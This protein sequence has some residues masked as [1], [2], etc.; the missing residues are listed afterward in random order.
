MKIGIY[1][2]GLGQSVASETVVKY[3]TRLKN[4]YS[5]HK[6]GTQYDLKVE[7]IKYTTERESNVVSIIEKQGADEKVMYRFYEFKYGDILTAVYNRKNILLKN[8]MLLSV[9]LQKTPVLFARL[10]NGRGYNRQGQTLYIFSLFFVIAAAIL[11]MVPATLT[12]ISGFFLEKPVVEFLAANQWIHKTAAFFHITHHGVKQFSQ[13]F[14]SLTAI[15]LL[16]VPKANVIITGLATEFVC[17]HFYLQYGQQKQD[18][19]GNIDQLVEYIV[20]HEDDP[21]IHFHTYSFGS[22][23]AM[24]Y[25]FAFGKTPSGNMVERTESLLTIGTPFDFINA[26]YP[27]YYDQRSNVLDAKITWLNVYS[28]TDALASNFRKDGNKGDAE[29][30]ISENAILKPD[31]LNYEVVNVSSNNFWGALFLNSVKAHGMYW[32][33]STDGSSCLSVVY[34]TFKAKGLI[35]V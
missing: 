23:V 10:F 14:V 2:D 34:D 16:V 12:L 28:V 29:Y 17:A 31:N 7:K 11:F 1:I 13:V 8:A 9:V 18:I 27:E 24:D 20:E 4:E 35:T 25:L 5:Y 6:R 32:S 26:Y 22:L 21:K 19:L 15:V 3:A 33:E 30:G